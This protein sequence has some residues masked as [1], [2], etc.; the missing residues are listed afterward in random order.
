MKR[1]RRPIVLA[2]LGAG[3][4]G[5]IVGASVEAGSKPA[6]VAATVTTITETA[7]ATETATET[8]TQ[9]APA[10][11]ITAQPPGPSGTIP[12][13][14]TFIPGVDFHP[15]TYRTAGATGTDCYWARLS[16]LTGSNDILANN[17]VTGPTVV[18]ISGSDK[19]FQTSGCQ[20]W[21]RVR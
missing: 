12:G 15:G 1:S 5:L 21:K 4:L 18:T 17:N 6:P 16:N 7:T 19:G 11:T 8:A 20:D 14:G 2:V 3:L 9:T 10:V 13:D